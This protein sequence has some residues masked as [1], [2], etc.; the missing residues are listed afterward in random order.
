MRGKSRE[1]ERLKCKV[2]GSGEDDY[3][4]TKSGK[5]RSETVAP[6]LPSLLKTTIGI[7]SVGSILNRS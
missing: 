2:Y 1:E 6:I 3:V 5:S 4:Q 7:G